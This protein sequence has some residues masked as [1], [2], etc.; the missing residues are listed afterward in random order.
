MS[1]TKPIRIAI[2]GVGKIV[3]DQHLPALAKNSDFELVAAAS[4]NATVDGVANFQTI[5]EMLA[6]DVPIDAVSLCQP[7]QARY[8][9]AR[10]ALEAGKHVFLEKPP[11][12]TVSEVEDLKAMAA[13]SGVSLFASWHSR[14]APAVEAARSF[15]AG[16]AARKARFIWKEDVRK[17]HPG[18]AWIWEPGGF[19]V[20]D[21]FINCLSIV[22]HILPPLHVTRA[23][24]D[25]PANR[26]APVAARIDFAGAN[27]L[28]A[29]AEIDWLQTGPQSW[30]IAVETDA[31]DMLLS[32]GGATLTIAGKKVEDQPERE[33][34]ALYERFA[35]IVRAG[36]SDVDVAPLQHVADAFMLGK[37]NVVNA[38]F[39]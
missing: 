15:L 21:P 22:T 26:D 4:R 16:T 9:A 28:A 34:P 24:L 1:S 39:D 37:R 18:Q 35:S 29:T 25:F 5:E 14:Y 20:F 27:S 13:Q 11:G 38:F 3:R 32:N 30:D 2:V 6:S 33:Y 23:E 7:P 8:L 17:W 19:G 12:A 36:R 10:A 31:G